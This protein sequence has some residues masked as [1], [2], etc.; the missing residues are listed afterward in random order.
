[1]TGRLKSNRKGWERLKKRL[2]RFDQREIDIGFFKGKRYGIENSNLPVATVA[3]MNDQ[4][5]SQVPPRPFMT[6]DFKKHISKSFRS[7][8]AKLFKTLL[9]EKNVPFLQELK[10]IG[11]E[12]E[13]E[14]R[15]IILRY[16]GHNSPRWI[17]QKGFDDPLY[18]TGTMMGSVKH[19][20]RRREV[21]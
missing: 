5:T 15:D 16:P 2:I 8:A 6:V 12:Y 10:K 18:H 1:M 11:E 17:E 7:Y 19:R 9:S 14:L 21:R 20:V 3:Y 13:T 4:G